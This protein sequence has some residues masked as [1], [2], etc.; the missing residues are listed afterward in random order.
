MKR[1]IGKGQIEWTNHI[2]NFIAVCL[3]IIITFAGQGLINSIAE[4]KEVKSSLLLV[5]N[6]LLDNMSY[7]ELSDSVMNMFSQAGKFLIRYEGHYNDAPKDSMMMHCYVPFIVYEITHSEEALELLKNS[8]LFTKIK[9]FNL[10]LDI[11][12]TYG[13]IK[14]EMKVISLYL[15]QKRKYLDDALVGKAKHA[16]SQED[17]TAVQLWNA[18]TSTN[19][20]KQLLR[21]L[22]HMNVTHD[23]SSTKE[24]IQKTIKA[25]D[26]YI[27]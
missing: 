26:Q 15:E 5:K 22:Y 13:A 27:N 23:S 24:A 10:S 3:G 16:I 1:L 21:E 7:I 14:D 19:E 2:L 8:S 18:M 9:D 12:H 17:I 4:R 20:G 11:I 6:E 25:I